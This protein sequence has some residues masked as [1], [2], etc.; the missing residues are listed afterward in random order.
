[1]QVPLLSCNVAMPKV[2]GLW[3]GQEV[4]SGFDKQPVAH[5][6]VFVSKTGIAGDGQADLENHGGDDKAVYAYPSVNWPWWQNQ[7]QLSCRPGL[8]GENLTLGSIDE[9]TVHLGDRFLWG[10]VVLEVSQPR[11]PCFKLGIYTDRPELPAAMT[12]SGLC[13][14]YFR[15]LQTGNAPS[16]GCLQR[17]HEAENAASIREAFTAVFAKQ[18]DL[19]LLQRVQSSPAVSLAWRHQIDKRIAAVKR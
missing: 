4:L 9:T 8:F 11:A 6:V 16:G 18:P 10:D 13:G 14:W 17:I 12:M 5:A 3:R 19:A 15:V 2:I 1:M 7:K